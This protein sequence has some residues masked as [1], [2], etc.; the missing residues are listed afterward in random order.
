MMFDPEFNIM[1]TVEDGEIVMDQYLDLYVDETG[2]V[3]DIYRTYLG[4][5]DVEE[6]IEVLK[7]CL[8]ELEGEYDE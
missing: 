8:E 3:L 6:M 2:P 7:I 5:E 1:F 4:K